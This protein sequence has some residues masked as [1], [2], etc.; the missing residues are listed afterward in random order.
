MERTI[1][2]YT[3]EWNDYEEIDLPCGTAVLHV[4]IHDDKLC[5]W[6]L[7][8]PDEELLMKRRFRIAGTGHPLADGEIFEHVGTVM[9]ENGALV[10]HVFEVIEHLIPPYEE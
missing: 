3:L 5:L 7:V 8:F 1:W 2:K 10:F 6:C 9:L 4:G